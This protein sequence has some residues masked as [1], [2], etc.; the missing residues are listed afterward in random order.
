[1]PSVVNITGTLRFDTRQAELSLR[2]LEQQAKQAVGTNLF[3]GANNG[4]KDFDAF[5]GRATNRVVAFSAA[6]KVFNTLENTFR[7]LVKAT[8]DVEQAIARINV[9]L[10]QSAS[11]LKSFT[12][13]LFDVARETG[14]SFQVAAKAAEELARQGLG[15]EDTLK[16]VKDALI[17]SRIA[18]ID[19]VT[20][21]ETL[22][23]AYNTFRKEALTT[24]DIVNKL[25]AVDT[26]FAVSSSD[27]A[28]AIARVGSTAQDAGVQ[29]DQLLGIVTSVQQTTQRGGAVIGNALKTIFTRIQ[30]PETLD[31][32][33]QIGVAVK[34]VE[35]KTLPAIRVLQNLSDVYGDLSQSQQTVISKQVAGTYQINI[36][37]ATLA[38]LNKEYSTYNRALKTSSEA[39]TEAIQKNAQLNETLATSINATK[40]SIEQLFSSLG[41]QDAGPVVKALL[42]GLE[43]VRKYLSGD[44]GE[45]LGKTLGDGI[46]K[47]IANVLTGPGLVAVALVIGRTI[48]KVAATIRSEVQ[49][50][51]GLNNASEKRAQ[52]QDRINFL[53]KQATSEENAQVAAATNLLQRKEAI[54]AIS[55]RIAREELLGTPLQNS[56]ISKK[57]SGGFRVDPKL[58][59]VPSYANP[60]GGAIARERAAGIPVSKIYVDS[61]PR[62]A[63]PGNPGGLL[64]ANTRDEPLGGFQGV[65]RVIAAGG[66]PKTAGTAPNFALTGRDLPFVPKKAL[67]EINKLLSAAETATSRVAAEAELSKVTEKFV[68]TDTL[69][70]Q[71]TKKVASETARILSERIELDRKIEISRLKSAK[72]AASFIEQDERLADLRGRLQ[73]EAA[74]VVK[75]Q[76][77]Q[78]NQRQEGLNAFRSPIGPSSSLF[79]KAEDERIGAIRKGAQGYESPI[80]P[81]DQGR[82]EFN[83]RLAE[84]SSLALGE[85]MARNASVGSSTEPQGIPPVIATQSRASR[86]TLTSAQRRSLREA[87]ELDQIAKRNRLNN[88]SLGITIAAPFAAGFVPEA[89]RNDSTLTRASLGAARGGLQGAGF[90]GVFGPEGAAIGAA[91]G[92]LAGGI[93]KADKSIEE[94]AQDLQ[95]SA[96]SRAQENDAIQKSLQLQEQLNTAREEG[97]GANVIKKL[98][99]QLADARIGVATPAGK[100]ILSEQD[101]KRRQQLIDENDTNTD[102]LNRN[103]LITQQARVIDDQKGVFKKT[104]LFLD[105]AQ[106]NI[107]YFTGPAGKLLTDLA[108]NAAAK[109]FPGPIDLI[110]KLGGG[111]ILRSIGEAFT[112]PREIDRQSRDVTTSLSQSLRGQDFKNVNRGAL[113]GNLADDAFSPE[114]ALNLSKTFETLG[115]NVEVTEDNFKQLSL[116]LLNAIK[117][118]SLDNEATKKAEKLQRPPGLGNSFLN[119][120]N[121]E[122]FSNAATTIRTPIQTRYQRGQA[123]LDFYQELIKQGAVKESALQGGKTNSDYNQS[124]ALVQNRNLLESSV[125]FLTA[126]GSG[127]Y[128]G[129]FVGERGEYLKGNINQS[130]SLK[131]RNGG[132]DSERAQ[133]LLGENEKAANSLKNAEVVSK[134]YAPNFGPTTL[135]EVK[136]LSSAIAAQRGENRRGI[137]R[138]TRE[139]SPGNGSS[140]YTPG[141]SSSTTTGGTAYDKTQFINRNNVQQYVPADKTQYDLK[142]KNPGTQLGE[143]LAQETKNLQDTIKAA[144]DIAS[145]LANSSLTINI[146]LQGSINGIDDNDALKA[147]IEAAFM[148]Y[149]K[150][151]SDAQAASNGQPNPPSVANGFDSFGSVG[152]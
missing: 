84:Q 38:D 26:K 60:L 149:V 75:K 140:G 17:L 29:F 2:R 27:L 55:S 24:G 47:G 115:E 25:A 14:Q 109:A 36:L 8:I 76:E 145:T 43:N 41:S 10:N 108:Q 61:D 57:V 137:N 39:T 51:L 50:L 70:N 105:T 139:L 96:A 95:D 83:R 121:L 58:K 104:A 143:Q 37:K 13:G 49:G 124:K 130:L 72:R 90:G 120:P 114:A 134:A 151:I 101:P 89:D 40:V 93:V 133:F 54:L 103:G 35:G 146:D 48:S 16:R 62:V 28:D 6:V 119:Q 116:G 22:T 94:F 97:A 135:T 126:S 147:E 71:N 78:A 150:P 69:S 91:I 148:K 86:P 106:R 12:S 53:L 3:R 23:A 4:A 88:L 79:Y 46:L 64:I 65:N 34:D 123:G 74:R 152:Y 31:Q 85:Q 112:T 66:N 141:V 30:N 73:T 15:A 87:G 63:G 110:G 82:T 33:E 21:V 122:A 102:R 138:A 92:A 77:Q 68:L 45:E 9:N 98:N 136:K 100:A 131:A 144:R 1:M 118:V 127:R 142:Q 59:G 7:N 80:G 117:I 67:D 107:E 129:E 125:A 20:A 42:N 111:S 5:L 56:F 99:Q 18:G 132:A 44:T 11:G 52:V 81:R 19:S 128:R 32:L 113:V